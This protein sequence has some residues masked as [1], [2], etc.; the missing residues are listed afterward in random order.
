MRRIVEILLDQPGI[1]TVPIERIRP[2]LLEAS[3][4]YV[5]WNKKTNEVF[6]NAKKMLS[7]LRRINQYQLWAYC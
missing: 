7:N 3:T 1:E 2:L 4:P 6:L 5:H